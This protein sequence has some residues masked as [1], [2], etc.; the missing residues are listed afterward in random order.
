MRFVMQEMKWSGYTYYEIIDTE[1]NC[2]VVFRSAGYLVTNRT[3][4][5]LNKGII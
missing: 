2:E 1:N 5:N 4:E 3:L